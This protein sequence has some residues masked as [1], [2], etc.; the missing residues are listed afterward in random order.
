[1]N[2]AQTINII[3]DLVRAADAA[4]DRIAPAPVHM[5]WLKPLERCD[6][7]RRPII[8]M[9]WAAVQGARASDWDRHQGLQKCFIKGIR[10]DLL[11]GEVIISLGLRLDAETMAA[12]RLLQIWADSES[13]VKVDISEQY[14]EMP[15]D[16]GDGQLSF[17]RM[18][19]IVE[20]TEPEPEEDL[21][22]RHALGLLRILLP[23]AE[24]GMNCPPEQITWDV[25]K[26]ALALS[27][28]RDV[29]AAMESGDQGEA[30]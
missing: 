20:S 4:M 5:P 26:A 27:R 30:A 2:E 16:Q 29:V 19:P 8:E 6:D 25:E 15:A 22:M 28:A 18:A 10:A 21:P 1:M 9:L 12:R 23:V 3:S 11:K 24:S 17:L 13:M 7:E 14:P